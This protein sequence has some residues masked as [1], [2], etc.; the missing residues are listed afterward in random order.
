MRREINGKRGNEPQFGDGTIWECDDSVISGCND[1]ES[2]IHA[3]NKILCSKT[4]C[5]QTEK[6]FSIEFGKFEARKSL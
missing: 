6:S 4:V 1:E 5:W 3:G 2:A